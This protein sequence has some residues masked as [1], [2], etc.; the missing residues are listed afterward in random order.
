MLKE[1]DKAPAFKTKDQNGNAIGLQHFKNKKLAIYFYP[2][3]LT[4]TCTV[5]ACNLRDNYSTLQQAGISILGV[6]PDPEKLHKKFEQKHQLPFPLLMDEEQIIIK[7]YGVWGEKQLYGKK[8]MGLI[9]TTFLIS[10]KGIIKKIINK[11]VSKNH[12]EEII[13]GFK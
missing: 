10:E 8:Y 5:Q 13:N 12:A 2:K 6:S 3:G 4:E 7:A 11:P 9:R 1:G